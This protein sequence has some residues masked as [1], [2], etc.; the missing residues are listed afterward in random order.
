MHAHARNLSETRS[1]ELKKSSTELSLS[2]EKEIDL[3]LIESC[4]NCM[5][6]EHQR[7]KKN[8]CPMFV[9]TVA[10]GV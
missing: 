2:T 7:K 10:L 6:I 5:R 3:Q 1:I 4:K 9:L 8:R